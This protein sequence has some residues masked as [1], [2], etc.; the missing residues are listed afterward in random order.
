MKL[1]SKKFDEERA[2]Y[3]VNGYE[4]T[5]CVFDGERD[6]ES[7]LK[8][9]QN[10]ILNNCVFRLRY[11]LWH[12]E[13]IE[14]YHSIMNENCRAAMWYVN[15]LK[16]N[17][18]KLLGI[19]AIRECR[20][21]EIVNST[22]DSMEFAW[23]CNH[24]NIRDCSIISQY[25]FFE[26]QN[27]EIDHVIMTGKYSFQYVKNAVIRNSFLDTKDAFWHS[28]NVIVYDSTVK[29][30]YLGWYAK[31]LK[32]VRC[33]IIGTQ[34]LCYCENLI[35]EDCTMEDTDLA[36]ELSEVNAK[37]LNTIESV[38]NPVK[39]TIIAESIKQIIFDN[40]KVLPKNTMIKLTNR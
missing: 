25:P 27:L 16:I 29:G 3:G 14:I 32:F 24:M 33:K 36:F 1:K 12:T 22:V 20:N 2:L 38:K 6:G 7:Q 40:K 18:G 9:S 21:I 5:D 13:N 30:E 34:P 39:G 37:I 19:K 35:L 26:N 11:P 10:I 4:L 8:E 31:N 17:D 15:H 23:K 28:E